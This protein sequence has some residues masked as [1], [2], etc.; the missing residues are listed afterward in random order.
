[1]YD[2]I[3]MDPTDCRISFF[4]TR[5]SLSRYY[6]VSPDKVSKDLEDFRMHAHEA[7]AKQLVECLKIR[8]GCVTLNLKSSKCRQNVLRSLQVLCPGR[9]NTLN[10]KP[11]K[12]SYL[13][14]ATI[15]L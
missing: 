12:E 4:L 1:M 9:R 11:P 15:S 6:S 13:P 14:F 2:D 5:F 3:S 10:S 8:D 7:V